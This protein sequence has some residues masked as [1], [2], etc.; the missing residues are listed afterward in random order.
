MGKE[1]MRLR[2]ISPSP[3]CDKKLRSL[4]RCIDQCHKE[5]AYNILAEGGASTTA[6]GGVS[7]SFA[8]MMLE[9][10]RAL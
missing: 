10:R 7:E 6:W 9:V 3:D 4:L 5:W 8:N 2:E 1:F